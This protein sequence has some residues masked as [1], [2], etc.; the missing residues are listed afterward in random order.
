MLLA[1]T[2][3]V[4]TLNITKNLC[5]GEKDSRL[6]SAGADMNKKRVGQPTTDSEEKVA[7]RP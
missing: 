7:D 6:Y 1:M 3:R 5:H 4:F 2:A